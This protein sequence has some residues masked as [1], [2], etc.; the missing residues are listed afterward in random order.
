M[1]N[2]LRMGSMNT[3][4]TPPSLR[5]QAA[6]DIP[7]NGLPAS[8]NMDVPD[9]HALFAAAAHVGQHLRLHREGSEQLVG[10]VGG[11]VSG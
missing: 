10:R 7:D 3:F 9:L 8:M 5:P 1:G 11:R 2:G 4:F 6:G